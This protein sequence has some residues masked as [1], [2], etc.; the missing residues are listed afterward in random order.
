M[1]DFCSFTRILWDTRRNAV[2]DNNERYLCQVD[3]SSNRPVSLDVV[4]DDTDDY[5]R[6]R[7]ERM[8]CLS[9]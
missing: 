4:C 2:V 8:P 1:Y 6:Y 9:F 5:L 3:C 7:D